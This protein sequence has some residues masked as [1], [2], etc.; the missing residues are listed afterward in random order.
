MLTL[1][2]GIDH[3]GL[4]LTERVLLHT[5]LTKYLLQKMYNR[6]LMN[7]E[8]LTCKSTNIILLGNK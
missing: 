1:M 7:Q 6:Y 5:E 4:Y 8:L 2:I 3:E